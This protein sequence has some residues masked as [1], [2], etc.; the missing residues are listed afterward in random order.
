MTPVTGTTQGREKARPPDAREQFPKWTREHYW[1][2]EGMPS[3]IRMSQALYAC[4]KH[5]GPGIIADAVRFVYEND[6]RYFAR[7]D[8]DE[9]HALMIGARDV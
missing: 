1:K 2:G 5:A 3:S 4:A 6:G 8:D 7:F 9:F